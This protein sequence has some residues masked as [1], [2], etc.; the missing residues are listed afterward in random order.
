[1]KVLPEK[2][3]WLTTQIAHHY[4]AISYENSTWSHFQRSSDLCNLDDF[5]CPIYNPI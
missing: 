3:I 5:A 4:N 2:T 1:M